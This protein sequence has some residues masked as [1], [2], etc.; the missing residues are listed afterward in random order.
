MNQ[1]QEDNSII[2]QKVAEYLQSHP[3][4]FA[5]HS[6][7]L[8]SLKMDHQV[9]G[10]ISLVERQ[11]LNLREKNVKLQGHLSELLNN[12]KS[13]SDLLERSTKLCVT[14]IEA[15]SKQEVV[16]KLQQSLIH[17]FSVDNCQIWL[18]DQDGTLNHVNY[19]DLETISQL[20]DQKFVSN[21]PVCGRVTESIAQLFGGEA[22]LES[23]AMIPLGKGS[24]L[25]V[26]MMGSKDVN[27]FT[28]DMGT[29]FL[30]L[31]GDVSQS[32]LNSHS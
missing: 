27:L 32:C 31:I 29:L 4:F 12:A 28:A 13:N 16:D 30:R 23:F 14:L 11:I 19:G 20:S 22:S 6:E 15:R 3:D 7:L 24:K 1:A 21:E 26:I 5:Q 8:E 9:H 2:E 25:G 17:S 10:S 18:F